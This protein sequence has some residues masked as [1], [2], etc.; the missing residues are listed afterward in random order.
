MVAEWNL[1]IYGYIGTSMSEALYLYMLSWGQVIEVTYCLI[2]QEHLA[3][4]SWKL[5]LGLEEPFI[6]LAGLP[7]HCALTITEIGN[8]QCSVWT[9]HG[10]ILPKP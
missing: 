7:P 4:Y 3:D 2:F 5:N 10:Q 1:S 6:D 8:M 9:L